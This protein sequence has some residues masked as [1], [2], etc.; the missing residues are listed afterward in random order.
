M[1]RYVKAHRFT[2]ENDRIKL[3]RQ[4]HGFSSEHSAEVRRGGDGF[5]VERVVSGERQRAA[6]HERLE[7]N[8]PLGVMP[9]RQATSHHG[10]DGELAVTP[11]NGVTGDAGGGIP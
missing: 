9:L 3:V 4:T 11:N 1:S 10:N 6:P 5:P 2:A 8:S 7:G